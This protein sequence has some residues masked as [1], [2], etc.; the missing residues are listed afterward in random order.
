VT[1]GPE[2]TRGAG[3]RA[4]PALD[5]RPAEAAENEQGWNGQRPR[6]LDLLG[7]WDGSGTVRVGFSQAPTSRRTTFYPNGAF[8]ESGMMNGYPYYARGIYSFDPTRS[9]LAVQAEGTPAPNMLFLSDI[10]ADGFTATMSG[11]TLRFRRLA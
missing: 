2:A 8:E 10:A 7:T 11:G 3:A 1:P 6:T 5:A 9:L 4:A